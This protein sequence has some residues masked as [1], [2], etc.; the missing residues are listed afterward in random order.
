MKKSKCFLAV[1]M[2][3]GLLVFTTGCSEKAEQTANDSQKESQSN[4][5]IIVDD[6][7]REVEIPAE[8][9]RVLA[10]NAS[11]TE[12]LF[13][14]GIVPV[15][16]V[17]QYSIPRAE[18]EDLPDISLENS[19]NI[20]IINKI[21]PDLIIAHAR[22]HAQIMDSLE[23]TGAAVFYIDPSAAED[24]LLGKID[25]IAQLLGRQ[26]EADEYTKK[27]Q[28]KAEEL[29]QKIAASP[30]KTALLIQ[31]GSQNIMAAQSFC[32]WGRLLA[33]LG[34]ENIVPEEVAKTS[35]AGFVTFDMETIIQKDPDAILILQPGFRSPSGKGGQGGNAGEQQ[36]SAK[37]TNQQSSE[38]ISPE[39]L[40]S[41]YKDD[42]MWQKLSAVKNGQIYI[43]PSNVSPGRINVLEALD[44][45]GELLAPKAVK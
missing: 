22:N 20:E 30:I 44:V 17:S 39:K 5:S 29:S 15:G 28:E 8:P 37:G 43:I 40:L 4:V 32:F 12:T 10:L 21:E 26:I 25:L 11:M 9:Q 13:D 1:I 24:Q 31:G 38:S 45:M 36:K 42:P 6:L 34:I 27:V 33:C 3:L 23:A 2:V 14:L 19:P 41:M 7:G 35:K 16:K 18:A